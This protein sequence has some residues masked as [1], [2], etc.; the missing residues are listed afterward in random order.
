MCIWLK[1]GE[2]MARSGSTRANGILSLCGLAVMGLMPVVVA[3]AANPEPVTAD[4][5]FQD[6]VSITEIN[7]MQFGL[8]DVNLTTGERVRVRPNGNVV[9]FDNRILGGTQAPAELTVTADPSQAITIRVENV[10]EGNGYILRRW[11][12][13]YNG[14]SSD[15]TCDGSGY[16]ETSVSSA[17]LFVGV[18]VRGNGNA[19]VGVDNGSFDVTVFYQ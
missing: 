11:R 9:D 6:P 4:M 15:S 8:L 13:R 16:S 10:V 7:P 12:C 5:T 14:A 19:T 2:G 18:D 17:S 3:D 1:C